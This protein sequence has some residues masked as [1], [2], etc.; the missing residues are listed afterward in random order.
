MSARTRFTAL[1]SIAAVAGVL[2]SGCA[3]A[4]TPATPTK[5]TVVE[6]RSGRVSAVETEGI[7]VAGV[8]ECG[9]DGYS[10]C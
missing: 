9:R 3:V 10:S 2:L 4:A 5:E 6:T 1:A 8:W 7:K